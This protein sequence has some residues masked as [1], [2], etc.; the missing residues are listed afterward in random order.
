MWNICLGK[1]GLR[2][3]S[4]FAGWQARRIFSGLL[5]C[6][7]LGCNLPFLPT[8]PLTSAAARQTLDRWNP[9]YCKVV[10]F[11]GFYQPEATDQR[12]AFV[13]IA[14][15]KDP[16]AK[17]V[18]FIAQFQRLN[19]PDGSQEWFLTSLVSHSAGLTRR[20]GWDNLL[21]PVQSQARNASE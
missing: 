18:I 11:Y 10:D 5:L 19:R 2:E 16:A 15:P 14:N 8:L 21:V 13:L 12:Q 3:L 4:R 20:Q 9:Q 6:A 17:P 7:L 1:D